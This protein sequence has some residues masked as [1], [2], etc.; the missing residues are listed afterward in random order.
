[1]KNNQ[2]KQY[3][4]GQNDIDKYNL[5]SIDSNK[6]L[7]NDIY[8]SK[9]IIGNDELNGGKFLKKFLDTENESIEISGTQEK[10][11][12]N[13][14]ESN[15]KNP[16]QNENNNS[17]ENENNYNNYIQNDN[18][19]NYNYVKSYQ[20][21]ERRIS[22]EKDEDDK[23]IDDII[24]GVKAS[25]NNENQFKEEPNEINGNEFDDNFDDI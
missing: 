8:K 20:Y 22:T 16:F 2:F 17:V 3:K 14:N 9:E 4:S 7:N 21:S 18:Y 10:D 6:Y 25:Q 13:N 1:M 19:E 11:N 12:N 24:K 15:I 5:K 23:F